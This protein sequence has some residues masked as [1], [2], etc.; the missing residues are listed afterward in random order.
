[1]FNKENKKDQ[2]TN[3]AK[4][5]SFCK[6]WKIKKESSQNIIVDSINFNSDFLELFFVL[7]FNKF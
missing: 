3:F 2:K 5:F 4:F 7:F 1:M 6:F